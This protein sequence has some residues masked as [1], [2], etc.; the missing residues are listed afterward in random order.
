MMDGR[1]LPAS[2]LLVMI[3]GAVALLIAP[4]FRE[5]G[6]LTREIESFRDELSGPN[7]GPEVIARLGEEL[8]MLRALADSRLTPIPEQSDVSGLIRVLSSMLDSLGLARREI[9]TGESRVLD[10]ASSMPMT[11]T[12]EGPF[13]AVSEAIR[14]IESLPRLVRVQRLRVAS[15]QPRTGEVD[16]SGEVRADLLIEVFYAPRDVVADGGE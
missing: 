3:V 16:R 8:A 12:L 9:T 2:G 1:V 15:D 5:S 13:P 14:M 10:E 7:S 11:V 4:G 6:R